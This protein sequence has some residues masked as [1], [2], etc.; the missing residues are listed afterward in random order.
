MTLEPLSQKCIQVLEAM[1]NRGIL[2]GVGELLN[3]QQK[4]W[5]KEKLKAETVF[6]LKVKMEH[7]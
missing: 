1:S 5:V 6:L 2:S 3:A 4:L 7:L